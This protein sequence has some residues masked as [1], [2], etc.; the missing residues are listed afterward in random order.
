M[1]NAGHR[2]QSSNDEPP[3]IENDI[4]HLCTDVVSP[5]SQLFGKDFDALRNKSCTTANSNG[6]GS[7]VL[8]PVLPRVVVPDVAPDVPDVAPDVLP[9]AE[10]WPLAT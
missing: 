3:N 1:D 2:H 9:G 10:V 4:E 6:L 7:Y 8:S 5:S